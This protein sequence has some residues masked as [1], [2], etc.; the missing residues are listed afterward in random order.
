M[1]ATYA[2]LEAQCAAI[3]DDIAYDAHDIDDA[4][5][6]GLIDLTDLRDVPLVG[7][8]VA[9]IEARWP[10]IERSRKAHEVQRRLI[11]LFVEDVIATTTVEL[12][13][14]APNSADDIRVAGR[15]LVHFSPEVAAGEKGLKQFLFGR[16]YRSELVMVPVRRSEALVGALF[17]AYLAHGDMP[18][19]WGEAARATS[20]ETQRARLIADYIAGMTDPYAEAEYARLFDGKHPVE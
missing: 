19:R 5:R 15:T 8:I 9:D 7:P 16:V 13:Q 6:A 10:D 12:A 11:T 20:S 2:S 18:G 17:D 4:L 14:L 1:L 3:A